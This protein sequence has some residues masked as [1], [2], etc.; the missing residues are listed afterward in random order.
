MRDYELIFI[1]SPE[2]GEEHVPVAVEKVNK[3]IANNGGSV[4][5]IDHWGRRKLAYPIK[6]CLEGNYVSAHLK[7]NPTKITELE[8]NLELTEEIIRYLLVRAS[9]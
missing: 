8:T 2:V 5:E 7:L 6:R 1:L 4:G 9:D 3:L